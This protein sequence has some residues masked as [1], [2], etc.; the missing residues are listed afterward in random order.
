MHF[1]Q[2]ML[3]LP[4]DSVALQVSSPFNSA[5]LHI[6]V[7]HKL[8]TRFQDRPASVAI[9]PALVAEQLKQVPGN[10]IILFSRYTYLQQVENAL[11][12]ELTHAPVKLLVQSKY[13][14][15]YERTEFIAQFSNHTN[16][17]GLAVL[18][19]AFSEGIDL[20]GDAL[21][22]VFIATLGLPQINKVNE[23]LRM[24]LQNKFNQGYNFT[25]L[26]PGIQKVVDRK[27]VV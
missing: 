3:G 20:P 23:Y 21:K 10:A 18:G 16:L 12:N 27:S 19:G 15:E 13:M 5:Q 11:R 25:Y 7:A 6:S 14:S 4:H 9:I 17:L 26:Y 8:S 22:G 2:T 1:Y 24:H